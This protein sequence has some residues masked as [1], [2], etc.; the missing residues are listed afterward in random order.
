M[1]IYRGTEQVQAACGVSVSFNKSYYVDDVVYVFLSRKDIKDAS[2]NSSNHTL[3]VFA[4]QTTVMIGIL[5]IYV[6]ICG[7][8]V[9]P[10]VCTTCTALFKVFR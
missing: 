7:P 3:P 10:R 5:Q 9:Y 2:Q 8:F 1:F 6:E 4:L